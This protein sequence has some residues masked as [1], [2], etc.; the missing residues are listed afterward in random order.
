M[1]I[2]QVLLI[3]GIALIF[4][5]FF[6]Y[7]AEV[8]F[9]QPKYPEDKCSCYPKARV[10][11]PSESEKYYQSEEYSVC[12]EECNKATEAWNQLVEKTNFKSFIALSI[13]SII[14]IVAG[15]AL[16]IEAVSSGI[17]GGG[18]LLLVYSVMRHW[19]ILNK[20]L[21]LTLLGIALIVLIYYGY[22]KID[23]VQKKKR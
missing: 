12:Q 4:T 2:K 10:L 21:R 9:E 23:K 22:Q 6:G 8:V 20:Y 16:T 17:L 7:A 18:I 5:V 15:L 3:L 11:S 13:I 1:A 19:G 14:A